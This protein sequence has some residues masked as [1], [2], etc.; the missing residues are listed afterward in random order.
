MKEGRIH[1][2]GLLTP[3]MVGLLGHRTFE[4]ED[5]FWISLQT[6]EYPPNLKEVIFQFNQDTYLFPKVIIATAKKVPFKITAVDL[7]AKIPYQLVL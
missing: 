6:L 1:S 7:P 2:V 3:F 5:Y 4:P